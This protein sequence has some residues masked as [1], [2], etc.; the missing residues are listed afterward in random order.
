MWLHQKARKGKSDR[1]IGEEVVAELVVGV[2]DGGEEEFPGVP[3]PKLRP[4]TQHAR[5]VARL[6]EQEVLRCIG[7]VPCPDSRVRLVLHLSNKPLLPEKFL[8]TNWVESKL[9]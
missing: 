3:Q 6:E 1:R 8:M 4:Q 2:V 9:P 5:G 7:N